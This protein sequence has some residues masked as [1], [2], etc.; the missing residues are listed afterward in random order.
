MPISFGSRGADVV[1][2]QKLLNTVGLRIAIDGIFGSGTKAAVIRF[3]AASGLIQDGIV[4]QSTWSKLKEAAALVPAEI[5]AVA[6]MESIT[7]AGLVASTQP[8]VT[9]TPAAQQI[10][11]AKTGREVMV[12]EP[13][14]IVGS[15]D[16]NK[17][18]A[19]AVVAGVAGLGLIWF[20][21]KKTRRPAMAGYRKHQ[22][23]SGR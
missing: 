15:V 5:K 10:I 1:T 9:G 4:G 12:M 20:M 18:I 14:Y 8:T 17:K 6:V 13:E 22:L 11:D 21:A 23:R 3:Q 2:L 7:P 16:R 19:I